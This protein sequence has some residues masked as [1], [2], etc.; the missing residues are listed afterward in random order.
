MPKQL[1]PEADQDF[2]ESAEVFAQTIARDPQRYFLSTEDAARITRAAKRFCE[3]YRV[4]RATGTRTTVTSMAKREARKE[5]ERVMRKCANLI[6]PN[7]EISRADKEAVRIRERPTK[8][9]ARKC[10]R[11][12][13]LLEYERAIDASGHGPGRHG[14]RF[15]A[16]SEAKDHEKTKSLA[17]SMPGWGAKRRR[18][19]ASA[20]GTRAKPAGAARIEI[21]VGL[22]ADG[23]PMPAHPGDL[24]RG[25]AWYVR[26]FTRSPIELAFPVPATAMLVVYWAR[27][28]DAKGEV[29]PISKTCRARVEGGFASAAALTDQRL[30]TRRQTKCVVTLCERPQRYLEQVEADALLLEEETMNVEPVEMLPLKQRSEA[31]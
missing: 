10:P 28:A 6:R 29:G 5:A 21:F 17:A 18:K 26:S 15:R 4:A 23:E 8:L 31:A 7:E 27:W 20:A 12:P 16:A 14:L 24:P 9:R 25:R 30:A 3:A 11:K 19:R 22:V 13:P 2:A 1:F